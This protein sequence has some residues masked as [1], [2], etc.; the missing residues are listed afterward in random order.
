MLLPSSRVK[1][2][3]YPHFQYVPIHFTNPALLNSDICYLCGS[4]SSP[5]NLKF[6]SRCQE[7]YHISCILPCYPPEKIEMIKKNIGWVCP[8][9]QYCKVCNKIA[10]P[11]NNLICFECDCLFHLK[12]YE[13]KLKTLPNCFWKCPFCFQ[14]A[15]FF[16]NIIKFRY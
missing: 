8:K 2:N 6:C 15:Q 1:G 12:C 3:P 16:D 14:Y 7:S 4:F 13:S 10:E 5:D 9:C 11:T